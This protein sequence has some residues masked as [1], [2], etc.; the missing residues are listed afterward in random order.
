M[1]LFYDDNV[2]Y[3]INY[4]RLALKLSDHLSF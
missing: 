4:I 1:D 3:L 2:F